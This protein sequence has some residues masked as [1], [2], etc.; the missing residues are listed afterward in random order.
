MSGLVPDAS[1]TITKRYPY[2]GSLGT[3]ISVAGVN[4]RGCLLHIEG[5][6]HIATF[7]G[8][9]AVTDSAD[10]HITSNGVT[11]TYDREFPAGAVIATVKTPTANGADKIV[12]GAM[13]A[14]T[15]WDK[16]TGWTISGGVAVGA[17]GAASDL[18]EAVTTVVSGET[19]LLTYTIK[20][21]T[22]A[23][24]L[25]PTAGAQTLTAR[26]G[27]ITA[28]PATYSEEFTATSTAKVTFGKDATWA[29]TLDNIALYKVTPVALSLVAWR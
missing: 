14:D 4:V 8:S 1:Y 15:D 17:T 16:G 9:L 26:V 13:A 7:E 10:A 29:G 11:L 25:T 22:T 3:D 21:V 27:T 18:V 23:G 19:Y 20:T 6:T 28:T 5:A 12:N 24:T 2:C